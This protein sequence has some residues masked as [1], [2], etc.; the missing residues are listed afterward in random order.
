MTYETHALRFPS[1]ESNADRQDC[2]GNGCKKTPYC[3]RENAGISVRMVK[4]LTAQE[5][6]HAK[7]SQ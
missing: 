1:R 7:K 3:R 5:V 4:G 6:G 2:S